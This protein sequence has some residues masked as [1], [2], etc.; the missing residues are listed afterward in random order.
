[1][2]D[3]TGA[4]P[5]APMDDDVH[6]P[7]DGLVAKSGFFAGSNAVMAVA[8]MVMI[9]AFV[10]FTIWDVDYSGALFAEA[11]DFIIGT[12][13][14]FYVLVVTLTLLFIIYLLMSRF[15]S[16]KLGKDD[17]EPDFSTFSWICMLFSAG[18]GSG[19][20]YWGVAEPMYH[21]Q[22]NPFL[23]REGIEPGTVEAA[24]VAIRITNFH[25]GF[26]RMGALCPRRL[27]PWPI[28]RIAKVLP[29]F[30]A[31]GALPGSETPGLWSVGPRRRPDRRVRNDLRPGDIARSGCRADRRRLAGSRLDVEH[32]NQPP[33][34]HCRDHHHGHG[35]GCLRCWQ[36]R[37]YPQR[38][39]CLGQ[40]GAV[41]VVS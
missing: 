6:L 22:G 23:T 38:G 37:A 28:S 21:V 9:I 36:R 40:P 16:V 11:K 27:V 34:P 3:G 13:D 5:Q 18:L 20:I 41:V 24:G 10:V 26:A 14:W 33:Y 30:A 2:S 7:P 32:D 35:L 31:R 12:L 39:Q 19:L 8:S 17:D 25:W 1:M 4:P 15:G 29:P